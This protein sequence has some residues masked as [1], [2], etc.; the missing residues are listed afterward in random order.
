MVTSVVEESSGSAVAVPPLNE[1]PISGPPARRST[2]RGDGGIARAR[3]VVHSVIVIVLG[4]GLGCA[5]DRFAVE[6]ASSLFFPVNLGVHWFS[7]CHLLG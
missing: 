6:L 3:P 4:G 2:P 7:T 5:V 1:A